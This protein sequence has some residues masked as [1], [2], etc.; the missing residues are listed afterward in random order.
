MRLLKATGLSQ[1]S[2]G[3]GMTRATWE[4]GREEHET[5]SKTSDVIVGKMGSLDTLGTGGTSY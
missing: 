5:V 3:H 2:P 4:V 1:L